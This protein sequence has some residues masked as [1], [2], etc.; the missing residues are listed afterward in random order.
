MYLI[1]KLHPFHSKIKTLIQSTAFECWKIKR[2]HT[3]HFT[4]C[5]I[6]FK[7]N[8]GVNELPKRAPPKYTNLY[9]VPQG[10]V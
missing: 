10:A 2:L 1:C 4:S 5:Y 6:Y 7:F 9:G 3:I 8:K